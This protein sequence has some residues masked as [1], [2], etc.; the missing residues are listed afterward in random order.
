MLEALPSSDKISDPDEKNLPLAIEKAK[1]EEKIRK[2]ANNYGEIK[3]LQDK[4]L[5]LPE[6]MPPFPPLSFNQV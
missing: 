6:F 4:T 1:Q 3:K 5:H 2:E